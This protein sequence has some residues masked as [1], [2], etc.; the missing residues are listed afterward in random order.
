MGGRLVRT[1]AMSGKRYLGW[2]E[3]WPGGGKKRE[4]EWV[5]GGQGARKGRRDMSWAGGGCKPACEA[6]G[7]GRGGGQQ[8]QAALEGKRGRLHWRAKEADWIEG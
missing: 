8:R 1:E 7:C 3:E 5:R 6:G 4:G 2:R